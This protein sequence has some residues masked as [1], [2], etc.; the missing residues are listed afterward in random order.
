M[1]EHV[2]YALTPNALRW[3]NSRALAN[4]SM[5]ADPDADF[6]KLLERGGIS[7]Y[8]RPTKVKIRGRIE[9]KPPDTD[10]PKKTHVAD[11]Q[12]VEFYKCLEGMTPRLAAGPEIWAYVNHFHLHEYGM[13]RWPSRHKKDDDALETHIRTHWL[14]SRNQKMYESSISGRT[15]WLAHVATKAAE[16]SCGAFSAEQAVGL[17]ADQP[18]HYHRSMQYEVLRNPM[19]LAECVR[20]LLTDSRGINRDGYIEMAREINREAGA[21]LLDSVRQP[22]I[23]GLV[24][25][26]SDRLMR[27]PEFVPD[28]KYLKGVRPYRV[29]SLGAGTQSTVMALMAETG[30]GGLEKPD[31]AIFADTKWEPPHVYEHLDWLEKQ[32]SYEVIRVSAGN[33]REN[34]LAGVTPDG[35][36]FLDM[37]VFIVNKDGTKSVAARQCTNHYKITPIHKKLREILNLEPGRRAPKDVQVEMW[38]GI[39]FDEAHR[40]K[41]SRDEWIT[42]RFPLI[43]M[44]LTRAQLYDWFARRYPGRNLPRSACV[45]CPYHTNMEWKWL[46]ENDP[47]SFNDAVF[48]DRAMREIP[49]V[50]GTLRG[51]GY[52]H[53][54]RQSL[55]GIDFDAVQDYDD[56][57]ASECEGMCGV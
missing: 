22:E 15:W 20:S 25:R 27:M 51:T 11:R 41:P 24:G 12:A 52:L 46:K 7:D 37:P 17:F 55:D 49:Q 35:N 23:R 5:Y 10:D 9:L 43:E 16:A 31:I 56:F 38:M 40:M 47:K 3:L 45:G 53:R 33:I 39:S 42:N 18:E 2:L 50:R 30:W 54:E 32:L 29:L 48:V 14:T 1:S 13:R 19:I 28:R 6:A 4:K 57:M 36:R 44:E 34:V 26:S 8:R 21:R